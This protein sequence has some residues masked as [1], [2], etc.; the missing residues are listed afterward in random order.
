[1]L[2]RKLGFARSDGKGI[3]AVLIAAAESKR[4]YA[5]K[6][7]VVAAVERNSDVITKA[8]NRTSKET[9]QGFVLSNFYD[10]IDQ[11]KY[12]VRQMQHKRLTYKDLTA[13]QQSS[14]LSFSFAQKLN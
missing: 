13:K 8:V 9:L 12:V 3:S 14:K 2:T 6:A 1:M 7:A 5:G 10:T 4:L 11:M